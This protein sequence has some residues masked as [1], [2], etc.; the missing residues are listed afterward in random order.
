MLITNETE[1][2]ERD[3]SLELNKN[4]EIFARVGTW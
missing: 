2:N 4:N 1:T 3:D